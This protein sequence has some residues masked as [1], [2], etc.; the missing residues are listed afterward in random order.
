V[1]FAQ[2]TVD[3]AGAFSGLEVSPVSVLEAMDCLRVAVTLYDSDERLVHLNRHFHYI[4][5]SL[6]PAPAL[7]GRPYEELIRL[8]LAGGEI[9]LSA[10]PDADSFVA[11]RRAQLTAGDFAPR[12][13]HLANG[14]II[15]TKARETRDGWIILWTDV[16]AA[17]HAHGRL[18]NA[19]ELSADAFAFWDKDDKLVMC[20]PGF[21]RLHG[22]STDVA[23][24]GITF[25]DM[26]QSAVARGLVQFDGPAQD[27]IERRCEAHGAEAGALTVVMANGN[28]YL[29]R[30]R[31]TRDGGRATIYTDITDRRRAEA[32]FAE[33]SAALSATRRALDNQADYLADLTLRLDKAEK[34][35]AQAKT[36][37]LRT[38]SHELKTPLN[39]I[40]G[41][42]DLLKSAPEQFAGAQVGEYAQLIH[43]AGNGL[44]RMLNQILDL[45]KIAAGRYPVSRGPVGVRGLFDGA[46]DAVGGMAAEKDVALDFG[47]C[48]EALVID[49]DANA[50]AAML[51]QL[52]ENAVAFTQNG[53]TVRFTAE[54]H[55]ARVRLRVEDDGPGVAAEDLARIAEP[56]EQ[57]GRETANHNGGSGLGLPL[58][59]ALA[60][61]QGGTLALTST[62]GEGFAA[63]LDLPA[64]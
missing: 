40:I 5:R 28:A 24:V 63:T 7:L 58:V 53:G 62:L 60:E 14:R 39:A 52:A 26:I 17:R 16:T 49:G 2:L 3:E 4:F 13:I 41:F 15:E 21:A 37:F 19:I 33:A 61:L 51:V 12:D 30:E 10:Y 25:A 11:A 54:R 34:G 57:A 9:D 27:W 48:P 55:G 36:T 22:C 23:P 56:F 31:A 8:E 64:A 1:N 45:T 20:N 29:V 50:L 46:Y 38:M 42:S 32:A 47:S 44:L 35:A 59:K 6:P 43:G 18:E